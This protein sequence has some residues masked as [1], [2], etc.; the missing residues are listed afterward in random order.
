MVDTY[1]IS[2]G[3]TSNEVALFIFAAGRQVALQML[4]LAVLMVSVCVGLLYEGVLEGKRKGLK[5]ACG[6]T[7]TRLPSL[8]ASRYLVLCNSGTDQWFVAAAFR[9]WRSRLKLSQSYF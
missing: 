9:H 7:L 6:D 8:R 3:S 1:A 4:D 5:E 2:M